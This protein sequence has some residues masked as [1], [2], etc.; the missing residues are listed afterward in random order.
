MAKSRPPTSEHDLAAQRPQSCRVE[1]D[2]VRNHPVGD[3]VLPS[4]TAEGWDGL[5]EALE[6]FDGDLRIER[7]QPLVVGSPATGVVPN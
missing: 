6:A 7:N 1:Q 5:F 2:D 4:P 3:S